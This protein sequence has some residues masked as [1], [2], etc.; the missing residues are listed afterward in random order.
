MENKI[1]PRCGREMTL[2]RHPW[3]GGE[4][5]EKVKK[6][7][8][9]FNSWWKCCSSKECNCLVMIESEKVMNPIIED[10]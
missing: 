10:K 9:Y 5:P 6:Q 2:Q 8:Y 1:C 7:K 3:E 4:I